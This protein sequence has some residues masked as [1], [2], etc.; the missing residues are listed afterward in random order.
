MC[1]MNNNN[2]NI[3]TAGQRLYPWTALVKFQNYLPLV[4]IC[5]VT[6]AWQLGIGL[7]D[8]PIEGLSSRYHITGAS[9]GVYVAYHSLAET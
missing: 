4:V 3:H 8:A 9:G 7:V 6:A 1:Y 2:D 5:P